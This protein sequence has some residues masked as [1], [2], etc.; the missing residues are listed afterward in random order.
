M[1]KMLYNDKPEIG[2]D[3]LCHIYSALITSADSVYINN[4]IAI[5]SSQP[6]ERIAHIENSLGYL[7]DKGLI[8][9]WSFPFEDPSQHKDIEIFSAKEYE[10]WHKLINETFLKGSNLIS[11]FDLVNQPKLSNP[12]LLEERTSKIV[13]IRKEYWSFAVCSSLK[14]DQILNSYGAWQPNLVKSLDF[15]VSTT[16]ESLIQLLFSKYGIPDLGTLQGEDIWHLHKKN[17]D[18]RAV[19]DSYIPRTNAI[20]SEEIVSIAFDNMMRDV[21]ELL[22]SILS[23]Q[24]KSI[25]L[26]TL[27]NLAGLGYAPLSFLPLGNDVLSEISRRQQYGFL[28]FLSE[29]K[30]IANKRIKKNS[31]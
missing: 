31:L 3:Q 28:Y 1:S 25:V 20:S 2:I 18:F 29:V 26:N 9:Y 4:Q 8:K 23:N 24:N 19:V 14:L 7:A 17:G 6:K 13:A 27:S 22:H 16:R 10:S 15:K 21:L 12:Q 30:T 5:S 11:I